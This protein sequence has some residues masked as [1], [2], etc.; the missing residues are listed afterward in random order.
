[1]AARRTSPL[2]PVGATE[3]APR[4][5]K[6]DTVAGAANGGTQRELLVAL[7]A[8]I[9]KTI[10]DPKTPP[11]DLAALSRR[12]QELV[13]DIEAIDARAREDSADGGRVADEPFDAEAL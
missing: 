12:M 3:R 2:R 10:D 7:R 6:R 9:A 13:R 5:A 8:R 11:R 1:M 4:A